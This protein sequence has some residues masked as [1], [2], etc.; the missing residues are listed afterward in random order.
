M[1]VL[2]GYLQYFPE[3]GNLRSNIEKVNELTKNNEFQILVL[4]ELAFSGYFYTSVQ[5]IRPFIDIGFESPPAVF[6]KKLSKSKNA[7]IL[8]GFPEGARGHIYNSQ[9]AFFPNG[10]V[11]VYR[12]SHL[13]YKEKLVFAKGDSGPVLVNYMGVNVGM[14]VCFDWFFPEFARV[15]AL[16]GA[17]VL[18]LSAN[19]VL[20]GLGQKG[21]VVRSIE[22]RVFSVLSNRTGMEASSSGERLTFTGMS[23][24]TNE[25]GDIITQ[26]DESVEEVKIAEIETDEAE[27]KWVTP[28][29]NII[30]DRRVDFYREIL[31]G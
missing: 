21:M 24:I 17:H 16:K 9:Y 7:L 31:D 23:Q 19:L 18:A 14:M 20:P 6:L 27:N 5:E 26:S 8:S 25:R 4:P 2:I 10:E 12:K 13:F 28:L 22:N 15:L 11:R 3:K 1:K 30:D 29:N